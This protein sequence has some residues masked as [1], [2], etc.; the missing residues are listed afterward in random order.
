MPETIAALK[1]L[2]VSDRQ[3]RTWVRDGRLPSILLPGGSYRVR[4]EAVE[5]V[6]R[7]DDPKEAV[8][9]ADQLTERAA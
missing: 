6:L 3:V 2:R 4:A 5:A 8:R 9:L 7:G 1:V